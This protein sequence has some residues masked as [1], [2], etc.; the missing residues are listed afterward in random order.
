LHA[1]AASVRRLEELAESGPVQV[2]SIQDG[3]GKIGAFIRRTA[4]ETEINE[5]EDNILHLLTEKR[6]VQ[7]SANQSK[8]TKQQGT[9]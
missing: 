5:V 8:G 7:M 9:G 4:E 1:G 3:I 6:I 2:C